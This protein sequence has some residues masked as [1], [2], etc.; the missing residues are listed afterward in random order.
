MFTG[1][2]AAQAAWQRTKRRAVLPGP[3]TLGLK[4]RRVNGNSLRAVASLGEKEPRQ[5]E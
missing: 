3:D 4:G 1:S 5:Q 2:C